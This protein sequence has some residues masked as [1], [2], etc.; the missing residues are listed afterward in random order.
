MINMEI[1]TEIIR[2]D[3]NQ[4]WTLGYTR[5]ADFN[6]EPVLHVHFNGYP[7][8]IVTPRGW[9]FVSVSG[10]D[11]DIEAVVMDSQILALHL[12]GGLSEDAVEEWHA[13]D[14]SLSSFGSVTTLVDEHGTD[15]LFQLQEELNG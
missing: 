13:S 8:A 10:N 6:G 1:T 9:D 12:M 4:D 5:Y 14:M 3:E 2:K 11:S 15:F 7:I